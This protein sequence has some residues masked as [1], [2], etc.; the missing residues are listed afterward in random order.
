M[1]RKPVAIE[2]WRQHGANLISHGRGRGSK[3]SKIAISQIAKQL[4]NLELNSESSNINKH[5]K[6]INNQINSIDSD[7]WNKWKSRIRSKR[8]SMNSKRR[9]ISYTSLNYIAEFSSDLNLDPHEVLNQ[10]GEKFILFDLKVA[11]SLVLLLKEYRK[12][13]K[14]NYSDAELLTHLR[15]E[16]KNKFH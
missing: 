9:D 15:K 5:L 4:E 12:V 14:K 11:I 3:K 1:A 6:E 8:A 16:V 2:D 10:L 13:S 7:I